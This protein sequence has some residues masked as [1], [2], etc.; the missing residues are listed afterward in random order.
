MILLVNTFIT[1]AS[2][3]GGAWEA[4]GIKQDRGNLNKDNKIDV[5]KYTLSSLAMMYP[6]KRVI[7]KVQLDT[8]YNTEENKNNLENFIREEF[9]N[10][11]LHF[12]FK[13]NLIQQ[14][15]IDTYELI[16]DDNFIFNY[17]SHDHVFIDYSS[18]Y[19]ERI[20]NSVKHDTHPYTT[21]LVSHFSDFIRTAKAGP[22]R[23]NNLSPEYYQVNY[24]IEEE[25]TSYENYN[26]DSI[27]IISKTLYEDWYMKGEWD[28]VYHL[29]PPNTFKSGHLELPRIDG[30]GI[31]DLNFIRNK[32]LNIP[33][34]KQKIIVPYK[35]L[36][37]HYDG[38]FYHGIT[39]NQVPSID[40]PI[41][42]FENNIKIR[43]GY[44]DRKEGWVNINPKS[45]YY[46]A[47]DKSGVDYK[48]TLKEIP[49]FWKNRIS[50]V[51]MNPNIDEEEMIQYR[52]KTVLET[53]YTSPNYDPYI[54]L[55]V[56]N[57]ILNEYIKAFP[58]YTFQ[59]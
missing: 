2:S 4:A 36:A 41:G 18:E 14:D 5:L 35:E 12:S 9:K 50:E 26:Y 55:E 17:C 13:R 33:T 29:Y 48:F 10:F 15:W 6:W 27:T 44:D 40:I 45:E 34:P 43:Y 7:I 19:I 25:Y 49:L 52:L 1:N 56:E 51:D 31:T 16:K 47:Y 46:Y 20:I 24:K 23:H 8:D 42:F 39:N 22:P 54:D 58:T 38:Y 11:E 37:R 57:K 21:I 32:V 3:T 53:V 30:V 28:S 59:K